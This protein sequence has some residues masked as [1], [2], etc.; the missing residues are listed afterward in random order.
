VTQSVIDKAVD[1]WRTLLR[2]CVKAEGHHCEHLPYTSADFRHDLTD[3]FTSHSPI[4]EE[5]Y[6]IVHFMV[7]VFSGSAAT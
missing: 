7:N 4:S 1:Q 2:A 3:F 6:R 5:D